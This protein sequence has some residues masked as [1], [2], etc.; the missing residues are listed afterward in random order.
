MRNR[1]S[2]SLDV[3]R[4]SAAVSRPGIDPRVWVSLAIAMGEAK[5]QEK[6]GVFVDV[7]LIPTGEQ[8]TARVTADYAGKGFGFYAPVHKDD[9]LVVVLPS[10][11]AAEGCVVVARTWSAADIP[12]Q[13]AVDDAGE[14]MLVV[15]DGHNLRLKVTGS[16]KVLINSEDAIEATCKTWSVDASDKA[17][18]KAPEV[19]E[20]ASSKFVA[21][22]PSVLLGGDAAVEQVPLGTTYRAQETIMNTG[23]ATAMQS[24][25]GPMLAAAGAAITVAGND[26]I[27]LLLLPIAAA[28]LQ[29]AGANL[30]SA[31]AAP[32]TIGGLMTAFEGGAATYLSN[33][34]KTK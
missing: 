8:Y 10:G 27:M 16:G 13:A 22:S 11:D 30:I 34:T 1:V 3:G 4:L 6:E 17:I 12:P 24:V 31:S 25:L 23:S 32:I 19:R 7:T 21:D 28:S 33:V 15:E 2:S 29:T 9:E 20:E 14:V 18:T 26:P 5:V